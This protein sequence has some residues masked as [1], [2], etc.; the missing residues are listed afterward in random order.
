MFSATQALLCQPWGSEIPL[1]SC[2][3]PGFALVWPSIVPSRWRRTHV[4]SP[5]EHFSNNTRLTSRRREAHVWAHL[6]LAARGVAWAWEEARG[7]RPRA[8]AGQR[9]ADLPPAVEPGL[10][11]EPP[12]PG[13]SAAQDPLG[14]GPVLRPATWSL[15]LTLVHAGQLEWPS[16]RVGFPRI[17]Q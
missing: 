9:E 11:H 1:G 15:F 3:A 16:A 13:P 17:V 6:S 8:P 2:P 12:G 7:P 5:G 14:A 4:C 10:P